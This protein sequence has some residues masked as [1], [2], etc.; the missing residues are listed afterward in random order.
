MSERLDI[1]EKIKKIPYRNFEI[2]DDLIKIIK[3]IIEGK[4][5]IM[6]S[7]IINLII[8]EGYL[9]ENYKQ[10]IIWCNYKIRLGKYF[11]EI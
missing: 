10:I 4:R 11:V 5:E 9:G 6:Y 3:K 2:L 8:R 7:D 1:I